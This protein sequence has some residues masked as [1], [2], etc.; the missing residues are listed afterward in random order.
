METKKEL[1]ITGMHCKSCEVLIQNKLE[2][3]D[4]LKD[5]KADL[6]NSKV[7]FKTKDKD[8]EVLEKI[9]SV[10]KEHGYTAQGEEIR[11]EIN[12]KELLIALLIAILFSSLFIIVQNLGVTNLIN[13]STL[14][15]PVVFLIGI[16][17]S[18]STCMAVVG[19]LVLSISSTYAKNNS[20][21][22]PLLF[23]HLSR[24]ISFL[25]L[26]GLL[27]YIGTVFSLSP[28]FYFIINSILFIVML[29]LAIN[30]LDVF[31]FFKKLQLTIPKQLTSGILKT[32]RMKT[33]FTPILL[34]ASTFFLPC[35]FTQ[36]MQIN[37]IASGSVLDGALI[38]LIFALGTLP[39]LG[40]ISFG[41]NKL[42]NST[43]SS[44]FFKSSGFLV[45]FFAVYTFLTSLVSVGILKPLF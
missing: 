22:I 25:I 4:G 42:A 34:G 11:R 24:L 17:A 23:F 10:I 37:A 31:P 19:G 12:Y 28:T 26:G 5:I 45:L 14:T 8:R 39:I 1:Y 21:G 16:I 15:Y 20:K 32:E 30:L 29:I 7:T 33:V 6:N 3:I 41:S 40:L 13:A 43:R 44:L 2:K 36:S 27:G 35:G 18:I 9:N 38:M